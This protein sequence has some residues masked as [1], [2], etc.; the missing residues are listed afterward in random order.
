M[1]ISI[2]RSRYEAAPRFPAY[3]G[4]VTKYVELWQGMYRTAVVPADMAERLKLAGDGVRL[5]VLSEDWCSDCF[6]VVPL[7]AR[8]AE[9]SGVDLRVLPRDANLDIMDA[10]LS[11]GTRFPSF[12]SLTTTSTFE[13]GGALGRP[14]FSAG[15]G[16]SLRARNG[17]AGRGP[18]MHGTGGGRCWLRFWT[19]WKGAYGEQARK[20]RN[21]V[22][23][24]PQFPEG[25]TG[26]LRLA[27][28]A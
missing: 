6:S 14:R 16:M 3:L 22:N 4:S 21:V 17:V 18:G 5:L 24:H 10:H 13:P 28:R 19:W 26:S 20:A 25:I 11:S 15:I 1:K 7:I 27:L 12:S 8:L 9:T 2:D 23:R